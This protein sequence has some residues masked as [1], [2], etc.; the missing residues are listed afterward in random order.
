MSDWGRVNR[1]REKKRREEEE[2]RRV[3]AEQSRLTHDGKLVVPPVV[4]CFFIN[5]F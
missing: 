5:N 3:E 1:E 2:R 4:F